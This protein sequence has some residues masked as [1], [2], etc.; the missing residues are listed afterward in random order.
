MSQ[1]LIALET[2]SSV[3]SRSR[4]FQ[5]SYRSVGLWVGLVEV[6][7]IVMSSIVGEAIYGDVAGHPT[8]TMDI[9]VGIGSMASLLYVLLARSNG[10]YRLPVLIKPGRY[11]QK[12]F[13]ACG[14]VVL[15][16]TTLLFLL[17]VGPDFSRGTW[18]C[19]TPLMIA[20]CCLVRIGGANLITALLRRDAI[21]GRRAFLVG[22]SEELMRI[23]PS[24]LLHQFGLREVGRASLDR[25]RDGDTSIETS[26]ISDALEHARASK[27]KEFIVVAKWESAE[28][29]NAIEEAFRV[30]PLPVRLLPNHVFRSVVHRHGPHDAC[31]MQLIDLQ[32]APMN[33]G[34]LA[35]KRAVDI[36]CASFAIILLLPVFLITAMAV[37]LD[38][39]GPVIFRQRRNGFN[40][41]QFVIYKFRTMTVQEDDDK[42]VQAKKGDH[43]V[44]RVGQFLRRSSIDELPQLFNVLKGDMALVGPRP[45]ALAHD[46]EY[47]A[48]I[49]D[50]YR[51]HHVKPGITGWAQV[52]GYRGE[53]A[54]TEQMRRRVDLDVWYI[55][56]WSLLTDIR[57][58]VRTCFAVMKQDAY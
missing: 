20:S 24:Y 9:T 3:L 45:H 4:G 55:N 54:R 2:P 53:T 41:D 50:Y 38:S 52:H 6:L 56:N 49:G 17:K 13:M 30:S 10:L 8:V 11:I 51:R 43:R 36:V 46:R 18:L 15:A 37:K 48:L 33:F 32:R 19:F 47:S 7:A 23:S 27:A 58:M 31:A 34:E 28:R 29:L 42:I 14:F 5:V 44:T 1:R 57:I 12:L 39:P 26:R 16:L 21:I 40:Q 25:A 35:S 22:E